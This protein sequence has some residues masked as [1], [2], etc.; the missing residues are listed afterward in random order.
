MNSPHE[1]LKK[2][3][4]FSNFREPQ[5]EIIKAVLA[6]KDVIAL[7]PTGGGKSICYQIPALVLEGVCLVISP[8]IALM[9]DQVNNLISKNIKATYIKPNSSENEILNLFDNIKFGSYKFLYISPERLQSNFIQQKLK[10]LNLGLIAIDEAHCISEW[11]HDFRPS[12][13]NINIIKEQHPNANCIALTATATQKV[14]NDISKNLK[15]VDISVFKKS[16]YKQNLAYQIFTVE[17]KLTRVKQIFN[18][19]KRPAI[20][21]VNSR[22][23]TE[24]ISNF[25]NHNGFKSS[26]YHGQLSSDKKK[27]SF[28]NWVNEITPIMVA[29]N[30]FGM[31]ID[32]SNVG[33]VIHFDT[34][35]SIENYVQESGRAGRNST[36]SF[37]VLL[38]NNH[39]ITILNER[40]YKNIPTLKEIKKVHQS[41][42]QNFNIAKGELIETSFGFDVKRFSDKYN[43]NLSKIENILRILV[44]NGIISISNTYRKKS[45]IQFTTSS[46]NSIK[47]AINNIYIKN[48]INSLLRSYT[49]LHKQEVEIDEFYLSK[50]NNT[51]STQVKSYLKQLHR[52]EIITY[53]EVLTNTEIKFLLPREDD[54][55]INI[56]S[57]EITQ[58]IDQKKEKFE[59]F[60]IYLN[61][62]NTCR[63]I[64]LL[65]YFG[66]NPSKK[67]GICDVC[68]NEK[69][70]TINNP[71]LVIFKILEN[72]KKGLSSSEIISKLQWNE[73]QVLIHLRQLL[74]EDKIKINY[75]NK[76]QLNTEL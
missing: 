54:K 64:Q 9:E 74:A 63:S 55:T 6:K 30:A 29:T 23:K 34:P 14:L 45:T 76:Y 46:K 22:K 13:R 62:N 73:N 59:R 5:Q 12:Y 58:F 52:D 33:V 66:E 15:L 60:L 69:K 18:K 11:G 17:D 20:V 43:F 37:A 31:G 2:H 72:T 28:N 16:F 57:K 42:Y 65:D 67:C 35:N 36:K 61:N 26:F 50:K 40:F 10:E 8:L 4:G 71:E 68:L 7:L 70:Q 56:Y 3:W 39:D 21:Y 24:E 27:I 1:I 41:L 49:G 47:Y 38:K 44:N 19:T 32:K 51:T 53:K 48:F 75:Q 25:L